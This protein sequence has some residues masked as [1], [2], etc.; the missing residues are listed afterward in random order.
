MSLIS[1][2]FCLT[3]EI[4]HQIFSELPRTDLINSSMVCKKWKQVS[5]D[6]QFTWFSICKFSMRVCMVDSNQTASDVENITKTHSIINKKSRL[7]NL[8]DEKGMAFGPDWSIYDCTS[9]VSDVMRSQHQGLWRVRFLQ[10]E[11]KREAVFDLQLNIAELVK[12]VQKHSELPGNGGL[13]KHI[14]SEVE[15]NRSVD[16]ANMKGEKEVA[17][18]PLGFREDLT[19]QKFQLEILA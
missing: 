3:K 1:A 12:E 14:Q 5:E 11:K 18:T 13:F 4:L 19:L 10:I 2:D 15:S 17:Q 9:F 16:T 7:W 6:P 8:V